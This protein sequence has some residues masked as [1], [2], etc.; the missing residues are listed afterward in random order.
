MIGCTETGS[1]ISRLCNDEVTPKAK[2]TSSRW[3]RKS[4][5]NLTCIII[6]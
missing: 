3:D 2:V 5:S 6:K 4:F 1:I